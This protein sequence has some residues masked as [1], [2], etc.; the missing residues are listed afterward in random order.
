MRECV[1]MLNGVFSIVSTPG[2]G[3]T[4]RAVIPVGNAVSRVK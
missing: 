3:T 1:E 4:I 2:N